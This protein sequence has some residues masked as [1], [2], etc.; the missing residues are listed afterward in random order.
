LEERALILS[1]TRDKAFKDYVMGLTLTGCR[2]GEVNRVRKEDVN[3]EN[4]TWTLQ[5][6]KTAKKTGK[7]RVIYLCPAAVE[8]SKRLIAQCSDDGPIFRNTR[9][10]PWTKNAVRIRFWKLRKKHPQ[11]KGIVAYTYRSSFA[12]DALEHGVPDATV[13]ELLGHTN[14]ST[15]HRFYARLSHKV[16]HLKNAAERA[17]QPPPAKGDARP[18]SAA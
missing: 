7:P 16:E 3:L 4:C 8:L 17:T 2:P 18:D 6:H 9:G 15:L 10:K 11:L 1:F 12:T 14:T 13:A 5:K